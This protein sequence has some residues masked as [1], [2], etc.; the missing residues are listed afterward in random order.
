M[1][2]P[3]AVVVLL[4]LVVAVFA[5]PSVGIGPAFNRYSG[6]GDIRAAGAEKDFNVY[7]YGADVRGIFAITDWLGI[8]ADMNIVFPQKY[9]IG[10]DTFTKDNLR[11][12][13]GSPTNKTV[14]M[15]MVDANL[16]VALT[17]NPNGMLSLSA[18]GGMFYSTFRVRKTGTI[19]D[20]TTG[21]KFYSTSVGFSLF[22]NVDFKLTD[23]MSIG[24]TAMPGFGRW[25]LTKIVQYDS[26]QPYPAGFGGVRKSF[27][28]PVV[29]GFYYNFI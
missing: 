21:M 28:L 18:G 8:Y 11:A 6:K 2:K 27:T 23:E 7:G 17:L 5:N 16:G 4:V 25:N 24:I 19:S 22:G 1:K 3:F 9:N 14:G 10:S 13:L 12:E 15:I 20:E 29:V 26:S